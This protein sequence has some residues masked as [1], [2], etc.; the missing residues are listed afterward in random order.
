MPVAIDFFSG[1]GGLSLGLQQAGFDVGLEVEIEEIT[2]RYA[3]FNSPLSNVLYGNVEG[4]IRQFDENNSSLLELLEQYNEIDLIV[5]GPPCQGFSLAGKKQQNDPLND[6]ILEFARV[7]TGVKPK[8]FLIENVPGIQIG[9]SEKLRKTIEILA[10]NYNITG[11]EILNAWD[12]GVPQTR[13]RVFILGYRK[14]LGIE[15]SLPSPTHSFGQLGQSNLFLE[16]TPTCWNAISDLPDCDAYECLLSGDRVEYDRPPENTYQKIMRYVTRK[17]DDHSYRVDWDSKIC[18]NLRRTQHGESLLKRLRQLE[19][20]KSDKTSSIRRLVPT[21]LSTTI[22]AGTTKERGSWSAPRPLHPFLDRVITTRECAR[23]QSF[24]D[25]WIFH[26]AKWHGNRMVGNA[27]PPLL[28]KAVGK[29]IL[30]DLKLKPSE[31]SGKVVKRDFS[32]IEEDIEKAKNSGYERRKISQYV[33]S[34]SSK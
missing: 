12:F 18:S 16:Q 14:D 13:R 32:L 1:V 20:G 5:G 10:K 9:G 15:P 19:P 8:A 34:W 28:G 25:Y 21:E 4:D 27:V 7:V 26:P 23:I 6:L 17:N 24:P 3:Q 22:R 31:N 29:K 11:P 33:A 30:D 2:G